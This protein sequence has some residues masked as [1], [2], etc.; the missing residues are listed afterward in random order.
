MQRCILVLQQ[1]LQHVQRP[2][3][4]SHPCCAVADHL[5]RHDVASQG[6]CSSLNKCK[7]CAT[8]S[9]LLHHSRLLAATPRCIPGLLRLIKHARAPCNVLVLLCTAA[10]CL[11]RCNAASRRCC[12]SSNTRNVLVPFAPRPTARSDTAPHPGAAAAPPTRVSPMR[13]P[14]RAV[15]LPAHCQSHSPTASALH[16]STPSARCNALQPPPSPCNN[17]QTLRNSPGPSPW[18]LKS[19]SP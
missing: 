19:T 6:C 10:D 17:P 13:R 15:A 3:Q 9:S 14:C 8:S 4:W 7:P 5:Q 16:R 11:Q 12:G 18:E 2:V 1:L